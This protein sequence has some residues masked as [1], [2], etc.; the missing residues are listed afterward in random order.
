MTEALQAA[1]GVT[2]A[3]LLGSGWESTIYALGTTYVPN[4][5]DDPRPRDVHSFAMPGL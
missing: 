1:F 2:D 4:I 5:S 3:D